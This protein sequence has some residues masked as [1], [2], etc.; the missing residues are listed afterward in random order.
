M[1]TVYTY[2]IIF[3]MNLFPLLANAKPAIEFTKEKHHLG[4][5]RQGIKVSH[6]FEFINKGDTELIIE[7]LIHS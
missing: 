4:K 5:V 7:K 1:S 2:L 6:A 3:F